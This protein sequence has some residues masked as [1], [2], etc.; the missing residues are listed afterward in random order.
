MTIVA[1]MWRPATQR[2][3]FIDG[4]KATGCFALQRKY[5]QKLIVRQE[6]N[7]K[8]TLNIRKAGERIFRRSACGCSSPKW[9]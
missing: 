3:F 4:G 6:R 2:E 8:L 5:S 1:A 7:G 9:Q